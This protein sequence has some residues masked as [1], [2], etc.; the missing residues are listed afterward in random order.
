MWWGTL[1]ITV[2]VD[3]INNN[4]MGMGMGTRL[5][6]RLVWGVMTILDIN[7]SSSNSRRV[8]DMS[9]ERVLLMIQ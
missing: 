3:I 2:M 7:S 8:V 1:L 9:P 6:V 5:L 4:L